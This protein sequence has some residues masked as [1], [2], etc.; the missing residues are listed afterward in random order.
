MLSF[1]GSVLLL[2]YLAL[3]AP[4]PT[5]WPTELDKLAADVAARIAEPLTRRCAGDCA[6]ESYYDALVLASV[7]PDE[8]FR[9]SLGAALNSSDIAVA[10]SSARGLLQ[11]GDPKL[12][13]LVAQLQAEGRIYWA[14][15]FGAD[16][17]HDIAELFAERDMGREILSSATPLVLANIKIPDRRTFDRLC[18][19]NQMTVPAAVAAFRAPDPSMQL[20]AFLWLDRLGIT[21][22]AAVLERS[23]TTLT[24][25]DLKTL[26]LR[27][28]VPVLG[29]DRLRPVLGI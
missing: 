2:V 5:D 22:D 23:W 10:R 16:L 26:L 24:K 27:P 15:G 6:Y 19:V 4:A 11:Y 17:R 8:R 20:A 7:W 28:A 3:S 25:A 29:Q 13:S 14:G 9:A 18:D 21:L 12:D 1:T